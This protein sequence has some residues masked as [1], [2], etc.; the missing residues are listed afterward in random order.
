MLDRVIDSWHE[1]RF[2]R[3]MVVEHAAAHEL[4]RGNK[5]LSFDETAVTLYTRDI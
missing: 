1:R 5:R 3:L 2:S 4:P